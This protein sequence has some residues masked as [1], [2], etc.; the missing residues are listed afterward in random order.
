LN[1]ADCDDVQ[2]RLRNAGFVVLSTEY[3]ADVFGSWHID[4]E[5]VPTLRVIWDGQEGLLI[6]QV[7]TREVFNGL[8][9]WSDLWI[10]NDRSLQTP[11][12]AVAVVEE[13]HSGVAS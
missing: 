6:V 3:R 11:E 5:T 13:K 8:R 10:E 12:R 9:V 1:K 7:E 2:A 4:V